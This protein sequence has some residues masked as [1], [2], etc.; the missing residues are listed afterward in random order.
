MKR[1]R[2]LC[3]F[4]L[5][6]S[7]FISLNV[8]YLYHAYYGEIDLRVRK[9]FSDVDEENLLTFIQKNPRVFYSAELSILPLI[10]SLPEVFFFQP[11]SLL[12]PDSKTPVLRC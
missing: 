8:A 5:V 9:H 11:D 10:I 6:L 7:I 12:L 2:G 4:L 3:F 1:H